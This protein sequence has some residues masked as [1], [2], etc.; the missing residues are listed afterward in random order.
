MSISKRWV[1]LVER[2]LEGEL[3]PD[4]VAHLFEVVGQDTQV[5]QYFASQVVEVE[6]LS[7]VLTEMRLEEGLVRKIVAEGRMRRGL[8]H[9]GGKRHLGLRMV[10]SA[11]AAA[12]VVTL[13]IAA[14]TYSGSKKTRAQQEQPKIVREELGIEKKEKKVD[15]AAE[16]ERNQ[17]RDIPPAAEI[18]D[19]PVRAVK[20]LE[21]QNGE[22]DQHV[23]TKKEAPRVD[24]EKPRP[25]AVAVVRIEGDLQEADLWK[26]V[27]E[28][29]PLLWEK[30]KQSCISKGLARLTLEG[31][32]RI[33]LNKKTELGLAEVEPVTLVLGRG[34]IYCEV[35]EGANGVDKFHRTRTG[36]AATVIVQTGDGEVRAAQARFGVQHS[37]NRTLVVVAAGEV[38]CVSA[39]GQVKISAGSGTTMTKQK[40]WEA[41]EPMQV[42]KYFAWRYE[43][44]E[45][46][47]FDFEDGK[48]P[49]I[50]RAGRIERGPVKK[51]NSFCLAAEPLESNP[52]CPGDYVGI[53]MQRDDKD[54]LL[55]VEKE[56]KLEFDY[57]AGPGIDGVKIHAYKGPAGIW[58]EGN[59][60]PIQF[61]R[62]RW[63]HAIIPLRWPGALDEGERVDVL[64]ILCKGMKGTEF[65]VDNIRII[66]E[67]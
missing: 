18:D 2:Y 52:I 25:E 57:W 29:N 58:Y 24:E 17:E 35:S 33:S 45:R 22:P 10:L 39:K 56:L 19:E 62:E 5:A 38:M 51:N 49:V 9:I 63:S 15:T 50:F 42:D 61:K 34:E 32:V 8:R 12:A 28:K 64:Q 66:R 59:L 40:G 65:Y 23:N 31:N 30:G 20:L 26:T 13:I 14:A 27:A 16:K 6:L 1:V 53:Q 41:P 60:P 4:E 54:A 11:A 36:D 48:R 43:L 21:K 46:L 3:M 47:A 7:E 67:K 44:E 37:Y 55:T